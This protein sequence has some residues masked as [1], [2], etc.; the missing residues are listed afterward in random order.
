LIYT[1]QHCQEAAYISKKVLE[2][3]QA[4][5]TKKSSSSS[6]SITK[7]PLLK[8][9]SSSSVNNIPATPTVK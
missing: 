1:F 2:T 5:P 4:D 6:D 8:K 7:P 3:E 9:A